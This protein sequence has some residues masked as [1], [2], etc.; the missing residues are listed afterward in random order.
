ME[1]QPK[2]RT[3]DRSPPGFVNLS[4]NKAAK[5]E[6]RAVSCL[7]LNSGRKTVDP[8]ALLGKEADLRVMP[9]GCHFGGERA[10]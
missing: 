10:M 3:K 7:R 4:M 8:I 9:R 6:V 2:T 5:S 1:E